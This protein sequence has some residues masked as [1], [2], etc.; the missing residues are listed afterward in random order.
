M[1]QQNAPGENC[2]DF[3]KFLNMGGHSLIIIK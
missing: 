1:H 2:Y 3:L